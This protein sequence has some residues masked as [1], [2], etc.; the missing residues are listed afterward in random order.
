MEE[1][2]FNRPHDAEYEHAY[3]KSKRTAFDPPPLQDRGVVFDY[4][5]KLVA[6]TEG[7]AAILCFKSKVFIFGVPSQGVTII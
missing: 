4:W 2:S 7:R 6:A 1:V 5:N 3:I